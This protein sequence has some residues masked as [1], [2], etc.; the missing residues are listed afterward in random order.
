MPY[1]RRTRKP[2]VARKRPAGVRKRTSRRKRTTFRPQSLL[3]V[4]FPKTTMVKLRYVSGVSLDSTI[5]NVATYTFRANSIFDPDFS[6]IGH[7]PMNHDT[8]ATL[9]NHYV[10]VGSKVTVTFHNPTTTGNDGLLCGVNLHAGSALAST[11]VETIME[12]GTT[13]YKL[14]NASLSAN[15]GNGA[16]VRRGFSC[17]K[18]F[19]LANPTDGITRIGSAQ[20]ANPAEQAFFIVFCGAPPASSADYGAVQATVVID[21]IVIYSEPIEQPQS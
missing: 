8:W 9:Y 20:G 1:A 10:V 4:G 13:R 3:R 12:Q 18:F 15:R 19:N 2:R 7:Q 14:V 5:G 21:Y 16:V 6:G 17:K 11:V